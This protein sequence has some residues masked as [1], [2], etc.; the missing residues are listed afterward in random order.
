[1]SSSHAVSSPAIGPS[2]NK[3]TN[4]MTQHETAAG[5]S[6]NF[7]GFA[8]SVQPPASCSGS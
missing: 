4:Q 3:H 2:P 8:T 1:M 5:I 6:P 7:V